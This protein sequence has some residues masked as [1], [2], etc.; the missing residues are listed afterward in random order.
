MTLSDEATLVWAAG[1]IEGAGQL[2]ITVEQGPSRTYHAATLVVWLSEPGQLARLM[3]A[4]GNGSLLG[5]PL[6]WEL[7]GMPA[8]RGFI[9]ELWPYFTTEYRAKL[10]QELRRYKMYRAEDKKVLGS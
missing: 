8:I 3:I 5:E 2:I 10:N 6:H 1:A 4:G 9:E 7:T